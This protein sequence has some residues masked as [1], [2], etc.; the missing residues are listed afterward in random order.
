MQW[1]LNLLIKIF[2]IQTLVFISIPVL[3][4]AL[5]RELNAAVLI[6][7]GLCI[8]LTAAFTVF[9]SILQQ[10]IHP[11]NHLHIGETEKETS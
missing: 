11:H 1:I 7:S 5:E 2:F 4:A 3:L 9:I 6:P 10:E 8:F